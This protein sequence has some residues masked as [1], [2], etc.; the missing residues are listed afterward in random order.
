MGGLVGGR[1]GMVPGRGALLRG[2]VLAPHVWGAVVSSWEPL[3]KLPEGEMKQ[4][5]DT[6]QFPACS[7]SS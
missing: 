4:N 6:I 5:A 7:I 2:N 1:Q 3:E